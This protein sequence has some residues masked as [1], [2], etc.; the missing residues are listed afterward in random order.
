MLD[1][2]SEPLTEAVSIDPFHRSL[3]QR[4]EVQDFEDRGL[5]ARADS[6]VARADLGAKLETCP[7]FFPDLFQVCLADSYSNCNT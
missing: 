1:R 7:D 6:L 2:S 3:E 5:S 4:S